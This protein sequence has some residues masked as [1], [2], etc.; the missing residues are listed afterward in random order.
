MSLDDAKIKELQVLAMIELAKAYSALA[1]LCGKLNYSSD[2][3]SYQE[4]SIKVLRR[5]HESL[6]LP[7]DVYPEG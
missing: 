6:G 1:K 2:A 5:L 3:I 4:H 7:Q